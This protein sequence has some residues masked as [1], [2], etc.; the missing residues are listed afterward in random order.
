MRLRVIADEHGREAATCLPGLKI[1]GRIGLELR[2]APSRA[3]IIRVS[4]MLRAMPGRMRFDGHSADGVDNS[5]ASGSAIFAQAGRM[6]LVECHDDVP[7][8][9]VPLYLSPESDAII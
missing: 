3:E 4:R 7:Y 6:H 9:K 8:L 2:L 5:L 1:L